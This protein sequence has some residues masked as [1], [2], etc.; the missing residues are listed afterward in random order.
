MSLA[1]DSTSALS[2]EQ[3]RA[4]AARLIRERKDNPGRFYPLSHNQQALWVEHQLASDKAANN[5]TF[6]ARI[7]GPLNISAL[8]RAFQTLV[9][10][11]SALRTAFIT[12]GGNPAQYAHNRQSVCFVQA[13]CSE[14]TPE[15]LEGR[16]SA[17]A[18][19][20]F[21]LTRGPLLRVHLLVLSKEE[22]FLLLTVHHIIGDFWSLVILVDELG[23]LYSEETGG[24]RTKVPSPRLQYSD[25]VQWQADL[26]AG[27]Q[28]D[29]LWNY[30]QH[31]L[32]GE[33]PVLELPTDR[34]RPRVQGHQ[35][36]THLFILDRQ[37]THGLT[38]VAKAQ[39]A[40]IYVIL[41]AALQL[42][43]CRYSGQEDILV[44]SPLAGRS[45]SEFDSVVGDFINPV[46]MRTDL[47][48]NPTFDLVVDRVRRATLMAIDHQDYPFSLLVKRLQPRRDPARSPLFQVMFVLEKAQRPDKQGC[49][50]FITGHAGK[51]LDVNGLVLESSRL[52]QQT[53]EYDL[54]LLIEEVDGLLFAALQY[55]SALFDPTTAARMARHYSNAVQGIV[56]RPEQRISDVALLTPA[57]R[58][59]LLT[60]WNGTKRE[61]GEEKCLH[62]VIEKQVRE[63]E[64]AVAVVSREVQLSY[65]EMERRANQVGQ[66]LRR[67]GVGPEELVGIKIRRSAEMIIA[68][69]GVLK[70]GGG[71]VPFDEGYPE[72]RQRMILEESGTRL[73]IRGG[74]GEEE[75]G[76]GEVKEV[77]LEGEREES[78]KERDEKP[79]SGVEGRNVAYV[80]YTSG[81]T[82]RPKGVAIEHRS[83]VTLMKWAREEYGKGR[84]ERVAAATSICFDLSVYEVFGTL[85]V[86]GTAVVVENA[87]EIGEEEWSREVTLINTV[88]S[89]MK[90]L[91]RMGRVPETVKTVNLAGEALSGRVVEEVYAEKGVEE[92]YNLYG[93]SEDT[94]YTTWGRMRVEKEK[95][96]G[97]GRPL[98]NTATYVVDEEQGLVAV[99][100]GGELCIGGE[101]LARGYLNRAEAT[102]ERFVPDGL[103]GEGG[104]RLYRTGDVVKQRTDGELEYLGRMDHQVKIRGFRIELAEIEAAL[105]ECSSVR[106]AVVIVREDEGGDKCLVGYL[107]N[108][109][110]ASASDQEIRSHLNRKLPHYMVP[111]HLVFLE[112]MPLT[113]NGKLDRRSLPAPATMRSESGR[114]FLE[115]VRPV[116]E[117]VA[118]IWKTALGVDQV[119]L[120]DDFFAMGGHSLLA[121]QLM[122]RVQSVFGVN[123][124]LRQVFE[125]PGLGSLA[126]TIEQAISSR[127]PHP[128]RAIEPAARGNTAVISF[129]QQ[130][131]WFLYRF[132]PESAVYNMPAVLHLHSR[133]NL[134]ALNQALDEIARRHEVLRTRYEIHSNEPLQIID[135][136][137]HIL[138]PVADLSGL[139]GREELEK[140][141]ALT[142]L[143]ASRPIDLATGP[144]L[145]TTLLRSSSEESVLLI[146][147]HH[148]AGDEWS[149]DLFLSELDALYESYRRGEASTL[150]ELPVQYAD[151]AIWQRDRLQG[152]VLDELMSY[153]KRRL[154]G[155]PALLELPSDRPRP[156]AQSHR[157]GLQPIV[158]DRELTSK[159]TEL[160]KREG[161]T[162]F[163]TSLAAFQVLLMR[164]T[165]Q[166]D[167]VVGVPVAGRSRLELE[168]L[169]GFFVN[170]V[171]LRT[172]MSHAKSFRELLRLVREEVLEAHAYQELPFEKLVE[173]LAPER[174]SSHSPLVQ[175]MFAWQKEVDRKAA[176]DLGPMRL[177][178]VDNG[179]AKFDL[180]L[181][182][183]E[184]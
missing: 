98:W 152:A 148:I 165:G 22:H 130:G 89:A 24:G 90:E 104:G 168:G 167:I 140:A 65:G 20:P 78:W 181:F 123:L 172:R 103:G 17:E 92:V 97:I 166:D 121:M 110:S 60:E 169:L 73:V 133:V 116:E 53:V 63:R 66:Y 179:T 48:G 75:E 32:A 107:I 19:I 94:T 112:S 88:P 113:P 119:G 180:T 58:A 33:L 74:G 51:R 100:V 6:A 34:P 25:Y 142:S 182:M 40:T 41:L 150:E 120:G 39:G 12:L 175:V 69:L 137:A 118:Q 135:G 50:L 138:L 184:A 29:R 38:C 80:I 81:S 99:G 157:G 1:T 26:L 86:G 68:M 82:G 49:S 155:M 128:M 83:T 102:A 87:L 183:G 145:R 77:R 42:L 62:E 108:D 5:V 170:T 2:L 11:H 149:V 163:M 16:L 84:M 106:E 9:D 159:L 76:E 13:D 44:G 109:Q 70:A 101:G 177:G 54:R 111:S 14:L 43:L 96:P 173:E 57:E 46:V 160:S 122:S 156:V 125:T 64:D 131:V 59:A 45:L 129:A 72:E 35:A 139:T 127:Q 141:G 37:L 56:A 23:A 158:V 115:P 95:R 61:V 21:E 176:S 71:Y 105:K 47:S 91:V 178:K 36:G 164:Y 162:L 126:A 151:Y 28:G 146:T 18:R 117:I 31:Q 7:L 67:K 93:P 3:K 154:A 153:W 52:R 147:L 30:W 171:A 79:E 132:A 55:S 144:V 143:E 4:L 85:A 27:P 114:T 134:S 10:R 8:R 136:P 15:E 174:S 124:P 161:V